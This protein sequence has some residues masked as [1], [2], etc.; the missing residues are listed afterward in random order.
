MS[1]LLALSCAT[2]SP[3]ALPRP[4]HAT[5]WPALVAAAERG[6]VATVRIMARDLSLG[7]VADDHPAAAELGMALGYLQI[8]DDPDEVRETVR[9]ASAACEACHRERR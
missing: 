3:D 1:L 4:G 5:E 8:A 2:P 6:D 7:D 9:E